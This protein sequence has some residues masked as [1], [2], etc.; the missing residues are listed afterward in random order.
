MIKKILSIIFYSTITFCVLSFISFLF[1]LAYNS[2]NRTS[3][4]LKIGFPLNYYNQLAV[5]DNCNGIDLLH[6]SNIKNFIL[7]YI[8]C[9]TAILIIK[10]KSNIKTLL[11]PSRNS[12]FGG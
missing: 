8:I 4:N 11:T 3:P 9:V 7:N 1:S 2:I 6:G 12:P 10:Y 5:S